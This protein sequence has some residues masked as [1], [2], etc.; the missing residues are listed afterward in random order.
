M[1]EEGSLERRQRELV[2]SQRALE[3][4][5]AQALDE[6]GVAEHDAGLRAA[7]E[8]VAREADEVGAGG[9]RLA[10]SRLGFHRRDRP[11]AQVVDQREPVPLSNR[12]DLLEPRPLFEADDAEVRL[13]HAQ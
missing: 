10:S 7:E 11:G 6:L 12:G 8:L 1:E 5:S 3:G 2:D 13:M 4:M 9:Q